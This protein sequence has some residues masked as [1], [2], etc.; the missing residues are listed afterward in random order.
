M[1]EITPACPDGQILVSS[2]QPPGTSSQLG[3]GVEEQFELYR[4]G[5]ISPHGMDIVG[6]WAVSTMSHYFPI[7]DTD[8]FA[9]KQRNTSDII[10]NGIRLSAHSSI[11][12]SV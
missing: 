2:G 6:F 12:G 4:N 7:C 9:D 3:Q 11:L 5:L 10:H 1:G 8:L